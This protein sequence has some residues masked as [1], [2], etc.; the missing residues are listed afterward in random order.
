MFIALAAPFNAALTCGGFSTSFY[1]TAYAPALSFGQ[2][3]NKHVRD[4]ST[5]MPS[6]RLRSRMRVISRWT[7]VK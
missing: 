1:M 3:A 2:V 5:S 6:R 4:N 7:P